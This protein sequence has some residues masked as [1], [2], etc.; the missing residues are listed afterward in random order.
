VETVEAARRWASVWCSGWESRDT[1][2]IVALYA[3]DAR[4]WSSPFRDPG[5]GQDGVRAYVQ[6]SFDEEDE[7]RA[8]FAE[9]VVDGD[10][11]AV[12]WWATLTE[13]GR[14]TTLAGTSLL[15]FDASGLVVSQWD[16]WNQTDRNQ[17]PAPGWA[18]S[19]TDS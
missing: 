10:R 12:A 3:A 14:V 16:A 18:S 13:N 9:P 11:A 7:I 4:H 1:D 8:W 19:A 2:A 17:E 15:R 6:A 5:V